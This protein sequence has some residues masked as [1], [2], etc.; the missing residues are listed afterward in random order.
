MTKEE[1]EIAECSAC[2]AWMLWAISPKGA[3]S[4]IDFQPTEEGNVLLLS[5][6][7]LGELLAVTL[8]G[9][10]LARARNAGLQ[11]RTSHWATCPNPEQFRREKTK[12]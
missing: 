7:G 4:P 6:S 3:R 9:G 10:A 1:Y 12:T 5:P 8:S 11:L 2:K